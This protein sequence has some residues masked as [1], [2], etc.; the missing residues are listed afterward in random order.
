MTLEEFREKALRES[1]KKRQV[2][3]APPL[4]LDVELNNAAQA[5]AKELAKA[6]NLSTRTQVPDQIKEKICFKNA[7]LTVGVQSTNIE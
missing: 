5:F 4:S 2:H 3:N 1:N 7:Y 6:K